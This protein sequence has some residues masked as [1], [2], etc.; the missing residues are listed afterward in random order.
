MTLDAFSSG[1][2][3][4]TATAFSAVANVQASPGQVESHRIR[5]RAEQVGR[6]ARQI[7]SI[8]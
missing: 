3:S 5:L 6:L 8:T 7:F 1:S 4:M 2:N